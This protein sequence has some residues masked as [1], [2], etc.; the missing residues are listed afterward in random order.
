M[1]IHSHPHWDLFTKH[2][3][4]F[5]SSKYLIPRLVAIDEKQMKMHQ[6]F[7]NNRALE[8]HDSV[9]LLAQN[10]KKSWE[11]EGESL[12]LDMMRASL[13]HLMNL[14]PNN[15]KHPSKHTDLLASVTLEASR[16]YQH[17]LTN[18]LLWDWHKKI[19]PKNF[20]N[21][22]GQKVLL[23]K[24]RNDKHGH[25]KVLS[26]GVMGKPPVVHFEAVEA[27]RIPQ[28]MK[29]FIS[30]CQNKAALNGILKAGVAHLWF[31]LIHP[32]EDGNGRIGRLIC[33]KM[34]A[35]AHRCEFVGYGFSTQ[36]MEQRS[37][38]YEQ[39]QAHNA[40]EKHEKIDITPWMD[41]FISCLENALKS[42]EK[43]WEHKIRLSGFWQN[44]ERNLNECQIKVMKKM[45][46]PTFEG[47]MQVKKYVSITRCQKAQSEED[48]EQ[49]KDIGILFKKKPEAASYWLSKQWSTL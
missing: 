42:A 2:P 25:M 47:S 10:I 31:E 11:I 5:F 43:S 26:L 15:D 28:E 7:M 24:W 49:L 46:D 35:Q 33:E 17:P 37:E 13:A 6:K 20:Q 41:W 22:L 30:W 14:T 32:F 21:N 3:Q 45:L 48:L 18:R 36:I 38:Y 39:L 19:F 44:H 27:S 8:S 16:Q 34:L 40:L 1:W 12:N 9:D 4:N 29:R 23:G